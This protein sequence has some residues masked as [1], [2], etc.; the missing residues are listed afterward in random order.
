MGRRCRTCGARQRPP[1]SALPRRRRRGRRRGSSDELFDL[2][3]AASQWVYTSATRRTAYGSGRAVARPWC[4]NVQQ[5]MPQRPSLGREQRDRPAWGAGR[6]ATL[7]SMAVL[8]SRRTRIVPRS[9]PTYGL[10][11]GIDHLALRAMMSWYSSPTLL[12]ATRRHSSSCGSPAHR[13]R[14]APGI[15]GLRATRRGRIYGASG[16]GAPA[17]EHCVTRLELIDSRRPRVLL[18][19]RRPTRAAATQRGV[20]I[21]AHHSSADHLRGG[22]RDEA[23]LRVAAEVAVA[24]RVGSGDGRARGHRLQGRDTEAFVHGAWMTPTRLG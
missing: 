3:A 13:C 14:T 2:S 22:D 10:R 16:G 18:G 12:L 15:L 21:A 17:S 19:A 5:R 7:R 11:P 20:G 6:A 9:K 8:A 1:D 24:M 23:V 4:R